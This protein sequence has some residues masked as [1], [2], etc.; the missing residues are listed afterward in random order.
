MV[1][2]EISFPFF[3]GRC[4]FWARVPLDW[5]LQPG[6]VQEGPSPTQT[7]WLWQ[8]SAPLLQNCPVSVEQNCEQGFPWCLKVSCVG[9]DLGHCSLLVAAGVGAVVGCQPGE[10]LPRVGSH[11]GL[12]AVGR[13][14]IPESLGTKSLNRENPVL[15]P[16]QEVIRNHVFSAVL[17]NCRFKQLVWSNPTE[18]KGPSVQEGWRGQREPCRT[19]PASAQAFTSFGVRAGTEGHERGGGRVSYFISRKEVMM[20]LIG[21][22]TVKGDS[23]LVFTVC[24]SPSIKRTTS[25]EL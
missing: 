8:V 6:C 13:E 1:P 9:G 14:F 10:L 11:P 21:L 24:F 3:E 15:K 23:A 4:T 18:R 20:A 16:T 2:V 17:F 7:W 5:V 22:K 25:F 12:R 19:Q